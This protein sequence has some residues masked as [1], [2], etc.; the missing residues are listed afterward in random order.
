[1]ASEQQTASGIPARSGLGQYGLLLALQTTGAAL[2]L[3]N[4]VPIYRQLTSDFAGFQSR[5]GILWWALAAVVLIQGG[6]W[7]RL[8]LRPPLPQGGHVVLGHFAAF[9]ARLSF[10]LASSTF[11]VVFFVRF[12]QLSLPPHRILLMLALLFSLFCWTLE[13]ER[14]GRSLQGTEARP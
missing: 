11:A 14:L 2:I 5:P 4:G 8:R 10:I 9:V 3:W 12:E 1:M 7:L 13:L 6:Y